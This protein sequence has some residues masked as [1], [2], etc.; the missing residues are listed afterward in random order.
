MKWLALETLYAII[1]YQNGYI[2]MCY[3]NNNDKGVIYIYKLTRKPY[4]NTKC[5]RTQSAERIP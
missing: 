5:V 1:L 3:D 4:Y 2:A